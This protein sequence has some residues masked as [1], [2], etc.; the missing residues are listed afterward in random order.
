[1]LIWAAWLIAIPPFVML[2][3]F[4]I[5]ALLGTSRLKRIS[6]SGPTP[7]TCI[8]IPAHNEAGIIEATLE[9]LKPIMSDAVRLVV[10]ADN[11]SDDTADLVRKAGFAVIERTDLERRGKGYALAFGRDS[12]R[13]APPDC[14]II[15]DA[16]CASDAGSISALATYCVA[17]KLVAQA[18]YIMV[19]DRTAS[20]KVQISNFAFWFKNVVR[21][22]GSARLGGAAVLT[23]TGMAF[24][25]TIIE[26]APLATA[27]IVEDL[28]LGLYLTQAGNAPVFVEAATVVSAAASESATLE[29]RSRW[30]HGF[31]ATA[32]AHGFGAIRDG[33]VEQNR[34]LLLL[35]THLLVPPLSFLL[36]VS[37][38]ALIVSGI[39]MLMT[40]YWHA[41]ALLAVAVGSAMSL[42]FANWLIEGRAWL[43]FGALLRM[44]LYLVWK[45]PVYFRFVRGQRAE[46]TRTERQVDVLGSDCRD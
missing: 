10:V 31:L 24:P 39:L 37:I 15:F 14:V 32:R 2:A 26:T 40:G 13:S 1:M 19:A 35:G 20:P 44:P 6:I 4:S 42:I 30:E 23:G 3:I 27:N 29:Q 43:G 12:L 45:L 41:F 46:W 38:A 33:L 28:A 36:L 16:D 8:L 22:R 17:R 18:R 21:Q 5:E 7:S 9:R 11:C 34:K 25:W